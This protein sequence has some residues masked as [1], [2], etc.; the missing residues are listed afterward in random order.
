MTPTPEALA[1]AAR[2]LEA[3]AAFRQR[4]KAQYLRETA[5][6]R[7]DDLVDDAETEATTLSTVAAWLEVQGRT[8][9]E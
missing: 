3:Y 6:G 9:G 1:D 2:V 7:R 4:T 5:A 8:D